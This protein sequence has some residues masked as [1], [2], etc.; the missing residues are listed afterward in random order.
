MAVPVAERAL[1]EIPR[2]VLRHEAILYTPAQ[3]PFSAVVETY[4]GE[5][6]R[7]MR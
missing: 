1:P 7:R 3:V 2:Y 4:T 6:L 5:T